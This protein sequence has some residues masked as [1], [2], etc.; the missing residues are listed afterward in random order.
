MDLRIPKFGR[1]RSAL[2]LKRQVPTEDSVAKKSKPLTALEK[3]QAGA[4]IFVSLAT[5][6]IGWKT[7]QLNELAGI[8]ND[9]LKQIEVRLS[10]RKFD[11]E[12][13]KEIYDRVEKYLSSEQNE[14]RGRALVIL[15][16]AIPDSSFRADLLSMLTV[17]AKLGAVSTAAAESYIGKTLPPPQKAARFIGILGLQAVPNSDGTYTTL[18]DFSFLDSMGK[19][20]LV[21]K[22]FLFTGSSVPRIAWSSLSPSG[23]AAA[24]LVLLEYFSTQRTAPSSTVHRMFYDALLAS[25]VDQLQAKVFYVALQ[26]FGSRSDTSN[27]KADK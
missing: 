26:T 16:N 24:A 25:G 3:F 19:T 8:N 22:G 13:F 7:F 15:V 2:W 20:W 14:R 6:F 21:P 5:A 23:N 11:F 12:Q 4:A 1:P 17:Q 18:T 9:R 27:Q 10:E